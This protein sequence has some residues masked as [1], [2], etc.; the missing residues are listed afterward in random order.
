MQNS[1]IDSPE[2][3]PSKEI[4]NLLPIGAV[5]FMML[6]MLSKILM[7]LSDLLW[8]VIPANE[9]IILILTNVLCIATVALIA[10]SISR[11]IWVQVN[12]GTLRTKSLVISYSVL[13]AVLF[14][15]QYLVREF[16]NAAIFAQMKQIQG[17]FF[18]KSFENFMT[19]ATPVFRFIEMAVLIFALTKRR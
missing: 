16:V 2:N 10:R 9:Y 18:T 12:R 1:L 13:L 15:V 17:F 7:S 5:V 6:M 8:F 3:Q 4:P 19:Y 14:V 11:S